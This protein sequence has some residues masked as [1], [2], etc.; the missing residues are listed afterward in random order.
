MSGFDGLQVHMADISRLSDA[1]SRSISAE[2]FNGDKGK[3]GMAT[4]G[5]VANAARELGQGWKVSPCVGIEPG[6]TFSVADI[7][8]PGAV[9]HIWMTLTGP[10]RRSLLRIYWDD[11]TNP[12]VECPVGDFFA[13]GW[14]DSDD[15]RPVDSLPG[16]HVAMTAPSHL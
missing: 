7:I 11:Q 2:K 14:G 12:S 1:R 9:Q 3:G 4:D 10:W 16:R 5:V 8:G 6:N 13:F 15:Y